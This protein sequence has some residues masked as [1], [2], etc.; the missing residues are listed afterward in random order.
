METRARHRNGLLLA[1][2]TAVVSGFAVFVNGYGVRAWGTVADATTYTTLKNLVAAVVLVAV[3]AALAVK[4]SG[5]RPVRPRGAAQWLGLGA[6][7][8]IGGAIPFVLFFEGLARVDSTQAAFIHKTLIVWVAILAA[9]TLG[10]R[11]GAAHLGAIGL[12]VAGQA[13]LIGGVAG[14]GFGS[15]EAMMLGATL[16]W[17]VEVVIAK[18]MLRDLP[19]ATLSIARMAG[20]AVLL[21][22]FVALRGVSI[23]T[24]ALGWGHLLWVLATGV[25]LAGYVGSWHLALARAPAVDVTAVLVGGAL[26]T[27]FLRTAVQGVPLPEPVGLVLVGIGVA[28]VFISRFRRTVAA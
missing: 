17:S 24:G 18:R 28:V 14:I 22:A 2:V 5:E 4:R 21:A 11:I 23:D 15:G 3:A 12:L 1:G 7:A 6:V 10:E 8:A 16:L 25:V 26:I 19:P 27:A 13:V 20:G 9:L